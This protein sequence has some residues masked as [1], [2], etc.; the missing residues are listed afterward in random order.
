MDQSNGTLPLPGALEAGGPASLP[1]FLEKWQQFQQFQQKL[2]KVSPPAKQ[3]RGRSRQWDDHSTDGYWTS[4]ADSQAED[5]RRSRNR[6]SSPKR[7]HHSDKRDLGPYRSADQW[8]TVG[9]GHRSS[10]KRGQSDKRDQSS[11]R[12]EVTWD[13]AG[14]GRRSS[15]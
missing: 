5:E 15:S 7:G 14:R 4:K 1:E 3:E 9:R 8:E 11:Y 2:T 13:A 6:T 10:S 12:N